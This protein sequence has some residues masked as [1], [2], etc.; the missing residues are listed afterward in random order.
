M[1][2]KYLKYLWEN[3][4][5]SILFAF[6]MHLL[7]L[8]LSVWSNTNYLYFEFTAG[9][10]VS[11]ISAILLPPLLLKQVHN[12]AG[13]DSFFSIP[14]SRKQQYFSIIAFCIVTISAIHIVD[15]S[16]VY[17]IFAL[18]KNVG[19]IFHLVAV[20]L[21]IAG[22]VCFTSFCFLIGN[23]NFDGV[24]MLLAYSCIPY[25][26]YYFV[27]AICSFIAGFQSYSTVNNIIYLSPFHC[28]GEMLDAGSFDN[29]YTFLTLLWTVVYF[30]LGYRQFVYRK[31]ER[32]GQISDYF[33]AYPFIINLYAFILICGFSM[34]YMTSTSSFNIVI[35]LFT[36]M[37][38]FVCYAIA[39]FIYRRRLKIELKDI[40]VF[41]GAIV[42]STIIALVMKGTRGF[43]IA[44]AS[45]NSK[46]VAY[47]YNIYINNSSQNAEL[48][49]IYEYNGGES[50]VNDF[51]KQLRRKY[52]D[53][54]YN[55]DGNWEYKVN[56]L[57]GNWEIYSERLYCV[58]NYQEINTNDYPMITNGLDVSNFSYFLDYSGITLETLQKLAAEA[59][60][61]AV[62]Y[63]GQQVSFETFL[64]TIQ[65]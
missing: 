61:V 3:H 12:R 55:N 9:T 48:T 16:L 27:S 36:V 22:T 52:N 39:K 42:L 10:V 59:S 32:A 1:N 49:F 38:I 41:V 24:V 58:N 21:A 20:T 13:V 65:N 53:D 6:V 34:Y 63:N 11:I 44:D 64:E 40:L 60:Y 56:Y 37:L 33:F 28:I 29:M 15:S 46:R 47:E 26:F 2:K 35:Y 14:V 57:T 23:S 7:L 5:F 31:A 19:F 18:G 4:K 8:A 50:E 45:I 17:I 30:Y 43:Q 25:L 62:E 51:F 54:F